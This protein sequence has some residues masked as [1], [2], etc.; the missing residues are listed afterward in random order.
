VP[1]IDEEPHAVIDPSALIATKADTTDT[2]QIV[3]IGSAIANIAF[4]NSGGAITSCTVT[5]T[6]P[7]GLSINSTNT[8]VCP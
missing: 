3:V 5:P 1:P 7:A 8:D 2:N 6:L 4:N